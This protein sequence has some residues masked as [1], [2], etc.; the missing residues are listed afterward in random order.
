MLAGPIRYAVKGDNRHEFEQR[1]IVRRLDH[2]PPVD[3]S[4]AES[5]PH[6][7]DVYRWLMLDEDRNH[8][9]IEDVDPAAREPEVHKSGIMVM[10]GDCRD[11]WWLA[12]TSPMASG[13]VVV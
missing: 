12:G 13:V 11:P 10:A 8:Q 4:R 6:I 1:V 9:I 5:R 7:A 3:L 2:P